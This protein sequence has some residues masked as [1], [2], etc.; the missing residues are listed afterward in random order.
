[1]A[2]NKKNIEIDNEEI[3]DT[4][5]V[6]KKKF[7]QNDYIPCT[8]ITAGG[9]SVTCKSG[10]YYEFKNYGYECEIEYRDL[11]A[12]I[13]KRSEHI[14]L[15]RFIINDDDFLLEFPQ[16]KHAYEEMYTTTDLRDIL[17]LPIPQM[18]SAIQNLPE[19][20]YPT[21]RSLAATDVANGKIDSVKKIRVLTEIFGSDFN[22]L[23]ELF[24][25]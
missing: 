9:L 11:V 4:P 24:G 6:K 18:K 20:L 14:F 8:S 15:P 3:E 2:T 21:L 19:A 22:L 13:R 23:S 7:S 25:N 5:V 16:V 1:M 17:S 12:L 10:N